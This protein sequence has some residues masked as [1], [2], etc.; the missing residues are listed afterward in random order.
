MAENTRTASVEISP[1]KPSLIASSAD[2][3]LVISEMYK[4]E[5]GELTFRRILQCIDIENDS[6]IA[7]AIERD[8]R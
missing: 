5:D 3:S 6:I 2:L 1:G 7:D 4:T 8:G